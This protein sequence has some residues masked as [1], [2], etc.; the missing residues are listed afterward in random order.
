MKYINKLATII[1]LLTFI[2]CKDSKPE[3]TTETVLMNNSIVSLSNEQ[4]KMPL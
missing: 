4:L 1:V 2:G 3:N